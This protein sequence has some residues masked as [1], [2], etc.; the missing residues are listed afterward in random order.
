M[1]R[2]T[3]RNEYGDTYYPYCLREDTCDGL[4]WHDCNSCEFISQV[5]SRLADFEDIGLTPEQLREV[6]KLY[7]E[8]CEELAKCKKQLEKFEQLGIAKNA[9]TKADRIRSM[10]DEELAEFIIKNS[11]NPISEKNEDMCDFCD[12]ADDENGCCFEES[13]KKAIVRWLRT[14]VTEE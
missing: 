3:A 2:L 4:G 11:D 5:C 12:L 8:K 1:E 6:D 14:K 10:S 13:C 7:T 9:T